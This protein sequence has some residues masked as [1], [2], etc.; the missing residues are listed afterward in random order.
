MS[1]ELH[2]NVI[3]RAGNMKPA[4]FPLRLPASLK[5]E[6]ELRAV[7]EGMSLN[8]LMVMLLAQHKGPSPRRRAK[9]TRK[10]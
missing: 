1:K 6:L 9:I 4:R 8:T 7:V 3:K 5:A 10:G 2:A